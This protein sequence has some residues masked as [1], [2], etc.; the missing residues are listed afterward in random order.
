MQ[1]F[2]QEL[3]SGQGIW[4]ALSIILIFYMIKKEESRDQ[5][6]EERETNYQKIISE[7]SDQ[8]NVVLEIKDG[9]KSLTDQLK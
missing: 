4:T 5:R 1:E 2:F 7:L 9:L 8:L 3:V 6:Q